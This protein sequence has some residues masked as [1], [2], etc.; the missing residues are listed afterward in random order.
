MKS[1]LSAALV[2]A[3]CALL[4]SVGSAKA[5]TFDASATLFDPLD[6]T[7]C[8]KGCTLSGTL[9]VTI[10]PSNV[11]ADITITSPTGEG[12]FTLIPNG[13]VFFDSVDGEIRISI[14]DAH[15]LDRLEL[16]I[17]NVDPFWPL[18]YGGGPI[19]GISPH[20]CLFSSAVVLETGRVLLVDSGSLTPETMAVPGPIVG[21]G[22]P[23][24]ILASGGLLGR[25]RRRQKIA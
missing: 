14:F 7:F 17:P 21:A 6:P 4:L 20:N 8:S 16:N 19:C 2:A 1:K 5:T 12:P 10:I 13:G 24:L 15:L 11:S 3:G 18:G 9:V 25:W 23:G 22:L